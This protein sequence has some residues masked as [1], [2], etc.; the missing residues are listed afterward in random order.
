MTRIDFIS[1]MEQLAPVIDGHGKR[2]AAIA[3]IEY[4]QFHNYKKGSCPDESIRDA[5]I[6][7]CMQVVSE[8]HHAT[9]ELLPTT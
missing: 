7:A 9:K 2:I 1:K 8:L 3:G 6:D 4:T 5:I